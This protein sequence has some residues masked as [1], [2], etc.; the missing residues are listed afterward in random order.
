MTPLPQA[1][2]EAIERGKLTES[3]LRELITLEAQEL[4]LNYDD[5]VRLAKERRLP[6]NR[7]GADIELLVE[8]LAA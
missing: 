5:A 7:L 4:G 3:Q 1:L 6:K 2:Q 8:L